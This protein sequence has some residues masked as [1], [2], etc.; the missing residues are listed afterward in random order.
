MTFL[1]IEVLVL[2]ILGLALKAYQ[3]FGKPKTI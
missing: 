3:L 1:E 2:G